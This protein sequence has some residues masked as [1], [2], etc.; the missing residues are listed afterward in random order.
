[1]RWHAGCFYQTASTRIV[2]LAGTPAGTRRAHP[3]GDELRR[4]ATAASLLPQGVMAAG[5][6]YLLLTLAAA[7]N[8]VAFGDDSPLEKR[9]TARCVVPFADQRAPPHLGV[10]IIWPFARSLTNKSLSLVPFRSLGSRKPRGLP[11]NVA[12]P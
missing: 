12:Q 7:A 8:Q 10:E 2:R 11:R 9:G 4:T 3:C 6:A 5:L 1:M